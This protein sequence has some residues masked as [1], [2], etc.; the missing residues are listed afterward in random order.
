L[1]RVLGLAARLV[2]GGILVGSAVLKLASPASSR[3]AL[4]TFGIDGERGRWAAWLLLIAVE[5]GLAAEVIA[6]SDNAAWLAAAFLA[7]FAA[8]LVGA[9]LRGRAGAPCACFGSRSVVSWRSV[10][11]NVA[12]AACFAALPFLP[13]GTPSTEEWLAFGLIVALLACLALAIAVLALAREVGMLRLRV[14]PASALEIPNEGPEVGNR[15]DLVDRFPSLPAGGV[16]VAVFTSEGCSVCQGLAPAISSLDSDPD[17]AIEVFDEVADVVAWRELG[18]PGSPFALA[19]DENGT[20]LAKG[21][22]NN[23]AQ[24]ESVVATAGRRRT[25]LEARLN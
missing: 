1:R 24:L 10:G 25:S 9:I 23:L 22:F 7:F 2:L 3:A 4:G 6:G 15:V 17:L 16:G 5:L 19:I 20:V 14:G 12:L 8:A 11:R 13:E 18:I 21:T